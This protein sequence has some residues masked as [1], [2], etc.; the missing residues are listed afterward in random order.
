M[1]ISGRGTMIVTPFFSSIW[2]KLHGEGDDWEEGYQ[3]WKDRLYFRGK[4][5]VPIS[6]QNPW[7]REMHAHAGHV[8]YERLWGYLEKR[9]SW[10]S[11][12]LAQAY[13][14][15]VMKEGE[16]CQASVRVNNRSSRLEATPIMEGPM[17]SVA[18]DLFNLPRVAVGIKSLMGWL[19]VWIGIRVDYCDRCFRGGQTMRPRHLGCDFRARSPLA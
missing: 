18:L 17:V 5:C 12:G 8:G 4:L 1:T 6:L 9:N 11:R 15:G 7:I 16:T 19:Y 3:L 10:A 13:A 2:G 14:K